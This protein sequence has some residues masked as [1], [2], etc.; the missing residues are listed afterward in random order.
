MSELPGE[1]SDC[2][3]NFTVTAG[4]VRFFSLAVNVFW[5]R[6]ICSV[7]FVQKFF[8]DLLFQKRPR[9][10]SIVRYRQDII[11]SMTA[12][13]KIHNQRSYNPK[14]SLKDY[15][16]GNTCLCTEGL[17]VDMENGSGVGI[18]GRDIQWCP[19]HAEMELKD[20]NSNGVTNGDRKEN[21]L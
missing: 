11:L 16:Q 18:P 7:P 21:K 20:K 13:K 2:S 5:E 15:P 4:K 19:E 9:I 3:F 12:I 6:I 8:R 10:T 14:A 1:R 17:E